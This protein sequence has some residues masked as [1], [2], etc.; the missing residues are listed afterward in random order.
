MQARSWRFA[1]VAIG[2]VFALL[3]PNLPTSFGHPVYIRSTPE[4]FQKVNSPPSEINVF[5]S[6]PIELKYSKISVTDSSGNKV[7]KGDPH[8]VE[9]DTASMG[10]SLKPNLPDG[11]FTVSTRVLSAVDG[12]VVDNAFTFGIGVNVGAGGPS[13]GQAQNLLSLPEAASRYPGIVGQ[14]MIVGGAF[15]TLWLWRPI[16]KVPWLSEAIAQKKIAADKAMIKLVFVGVILVL[17]SGAAMIV[18]QANSIGTSIPEAIATQFGNVWVARML[19]SSILVAIVFAV[20]RNVAK[21]NVSPARSETLAILILG[22]AILVTSSLIA[23]AA[24]TKQLGVIG[25]DFFH[26]VAA[27]VWIGGLVFLGFVAAPKMLEIA[28]EKAKATA[29]SLLIPRFSIIVVTI[30]GITAITGPLLLYSIE[31]DLSL[32]L[33]STYGQFLIIKLSLAGVMLGMGAYSQF[34]IQKKA[35]SVVDSSGGG[36]SMIQTRGPNLKHFGKF[37]KA[38]AAVGLGLLLMV[39]LMAN[40]S[41][42][43][44]QFPGY[45]EQRQQALGIGQSASGQQQTA[46]K[47]D[48]AETAYVN[49]GQVQ[50]AISPF[51]V[52]QNNFKISFVG[53][54]G[55]PVSDIESATIRMTSDKGI[56]PITVDAKKQSEGVF[57]SDTAFGAAGTW[58]VAIE[59]VRSKGSNM[60]GTFDV[61]VKP[62]VSNLDFTIKQYNMSAQSLPLFP[63]FDQQRQSIWI[64]DTMPGSG[65]IWQFNIATGKY[66]E[67]KVKG[68]DLIT[69]MT[70]APDGNLWY[71]EPRSDVVGLF[72]PTDGSNKPFKLPEKGIIT[73]LTMDNNGNLWMPILDTNKIVKFEPKTEKFSTYDI[74]TAN[75]QPTVIMTDSQGSIWFAEGTGK[76]ANINASS[77]KITEYAP[78]SKDQALREPTSIFEDP[79]DPNILYVSEHTGHRVTAFN[80]LFGTFHSYPVLNDAGAPFGM[81]IDKNGNLWIAEHLIDRIAVM[82]PRTGESKEAKVPISGSLV[83]YLVSDDSGKI[84]FAAQRG[85]PSLGSITMTAKPSTQPST[86]SGEQFNNVGGGVQQLGFS[87][88]QVAGP[89]IA[90]G[91]V[92][93][94]LVYAKTTMD[95]KRNMRAA[96]RL[97]S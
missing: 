17:A 31:S 62:H 42:P 91:I 41:T 55:K 14:I 97:R 46:I 10:V 65:R 7:D 78:K 16:G 27:A 94:A 12:H 96:L 45:E 79:K 81:A 70:L 29:I 77:G 47:T 18:V 64:G 59:G 76:I 84:W 82:D 58:N 57:V 34:A 19:Q 3:A 92:L 25:L 5:F 80:K 15:A 30:L 32:T 1:L 2:I 90:A 38:E 4:A 53:K 6:E 20:Y 44:G 37:L 67:H 75:A 48:F 24:A 40:S 35:V 63:V 49:D 39:S 51:D 89:G 71:I 52:G 69:I 86:N 11:I 22:F 88:A 26:D 33:A 87:F 43:S 72:N 50:L 23:H 21:K 95:L 9:G 8:N 36:T 74:P 61:N 56:G 54:D 28:D 66:I 73:G 60:I 85:Q 93:S 83:Q 13:T 68:A